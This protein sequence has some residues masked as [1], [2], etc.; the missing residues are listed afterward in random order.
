MG[1]QAVGESRKQTDT[2]FLPHPTAP[3]D[4]LETI[5]VARGLALF[6]VMAINLIFEFRVSIFEQFV[7]QISVGSSLDHTIERFLMLAVELKAFALFSI[8]FGVGLAIQFE[9]LAGS[10]RRAVLLVRRLAVLLA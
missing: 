1:R 5:D 2:E 7:G 3:V 9:R 8:L 10:R 6:G 4:R